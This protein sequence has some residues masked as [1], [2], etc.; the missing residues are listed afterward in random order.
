M[1][2]TRV[3][4]THGQRRRITPA[5]VALYLKACE[6]R[7]SGLGDRW[8]DEGGRRREMYNTTNALH[9]ALALTPWHDSPVHVNP[10]K[11]PWDNSS[12]ELAIELRDLLEA[13]GAGNAD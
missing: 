8:E 10:E 9:E 12:W 3:P 13:A 2:T 1:P 11:M 7:D 6:I 5:A 4:I